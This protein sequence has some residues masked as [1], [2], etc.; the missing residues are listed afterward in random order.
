MSGRPKFAKRY[1]QNVVEVLVIEYWNLNFICD[2]V[3]DIWD[4]IAF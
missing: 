2:L 4:F 1:D 3:L